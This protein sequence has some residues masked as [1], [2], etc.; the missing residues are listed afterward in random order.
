M[1]L[2]ALSSLSAGYSP[3]TV[4]M[5]ATADRVRRA[6]REAPSTQVDS[7]KKANTEANR[8]ESRTEASPTKEIEKAAVSSSQ[9]IQFK[10]AEGTRVME[11]YDSKNVL[12][13]QI[14][15]K[16]ALTLIQHQERAA[17]SQVETSA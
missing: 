13:Y 11:V 14:P 17:A 6:P 4:A 8:L 2:A 15:S 7:A 1:E 3:R 16:G 12:I 10:D 9:Q 5:E